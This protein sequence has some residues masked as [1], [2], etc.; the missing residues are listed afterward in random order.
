MSSCV[1]AVVM[2]MDALTQVIGME[3][4]LKLVEKGSGQR[5]VVSRVKRGSC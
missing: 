3:D 4:G 1:H 2:T 5:E